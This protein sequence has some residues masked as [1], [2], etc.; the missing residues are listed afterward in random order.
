VEKTEAM[1]NPVGVDS[2]GGLWSAGGSEQWEQIFSLTAE[3]NIYMVTIPVV[4]S[5]YKYLWLR[6][7]VQGWDVGTDAVYSGTDMIAKSLIFGSTSKITHLP[8]GAGG[9][10]TTTN[11]LFFGTG[12]PCRFLPLAFVPNKSLTSPGGIQT[13]NPSAGDFLVAD[14]IVVMAYSSTNRYLFTAGSTFELWGVKK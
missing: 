4:G 10:Y 2:L 9:V 12:Y 6:M 13:Y 8:Y 3:D 1:T 11:V 5:D 14:S 7:N